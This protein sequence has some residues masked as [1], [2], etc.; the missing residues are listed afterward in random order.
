MK[1]LPTRIKIGPYTYK[2]KQVSN[3]EVN[4]VQYLGLHDHSSLTITINKDAAIEVKLATLVHECLHAIF[5][6]TEIETD[7]EERIVSRLTPALIDFFRT[8]K[9]LL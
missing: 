5:N 9:G 7:K 1:K 3:L 8:N 4:R 6:L 2:I